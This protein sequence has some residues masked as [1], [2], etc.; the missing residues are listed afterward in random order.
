MNMAGLRCDSRRIFTGVGSLLNTSKSTE[1]RR[2]MMPKWRKTDIARTEIKN[3]NP[4]ASSEWADEAHWLVQMSASSIDTQ[5]ALKRHTTS[6]TTVITP[7]AMI[8]SAFAM[9]P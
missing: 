8:C 2:R 7:C 4:Y 1:R 6:W 5:M 9:Y 3:G